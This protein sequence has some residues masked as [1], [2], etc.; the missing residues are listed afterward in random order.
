MD[1][2]VQVASDQLERSPIPG[3]ELEW[4]GE[5]Y[6]NLTWQQ[7]MVS[8]MLVGFATT[9]AVIFALL[10]GLFRSLKWAL[11]ALAPVLGTVVVVYGLMAYIGRDMD[12]PVAVLS[13]M[14]L[15]IGVDFAIH[16]VERFRGLRARTGSTDAALAGFYGEPATAMTR[17]AVVIAVGFSPL[18]FSSLVP[19]VVVGVLLAS[20]ILLSWL[21]SLIVLPAAT[22]LLSS[23]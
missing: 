5:A 20:I 10:L 11:L 19:Y 16:F 14:V 12:M 21:A 6:L 15:G 2:V 13:T 18:L 8:G 22:S 7:E 1:E 9:L 23:R 17:N 4:A 3:V